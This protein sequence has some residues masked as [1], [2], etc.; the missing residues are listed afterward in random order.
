MQGNNQ[1]GVMQDNAV[2]VRQVIKCLTIVNDPCKHAFIRD[3]FAATSIA[4]S[5]GLSEN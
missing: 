5:D 3:A 1:R 2:I 4:S